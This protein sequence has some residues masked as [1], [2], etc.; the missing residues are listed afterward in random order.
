MS[1]KNFYVIGDDNCRYEGMTKEQTIAAIEQVISQGFISD[2]DTGFI[3]KIKEQNKQ[4]DLTFWVGSQAEYNAIET[5]A[6]NCFYVISNSGNF[7][8]LK[9]AVENL[10]IENE[11]IKESI[12]D[13]KDKQFN[14]CLKL[15][16][17]IRAVRQLIVA[18]NISLQSP[19]NANSEYTF[20]QDVHK[21]GY[22]PL[23]VVPY[24][25]T[26]TGTL[27][28]NLSITNIGIYSGDT[29]WL[30]VYNANEFKV[31][32]KVD[33]TVLYIKTEW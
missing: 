27:Y 29:L 8:E 18:K 1:E 6:E 30:S 21:E 3:T 10:I 22:R 31:D 23:C 5:K 2:V 19:V 15:E 24:V 25:L 20:S 16:R 33:V 4:K 12:V 11:T 9:K 32:V 14:D 17:E 26:T 28:V 7:A 13:L